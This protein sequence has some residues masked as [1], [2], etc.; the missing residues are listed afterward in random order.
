MTIEQAI[1]IVDAVCSVARMQR[2][3]HARVVE[4]LRL[5]R[6]ALEPAPPEQ[7]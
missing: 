5:I 4:A 3:D 2:D 7:G 6:E 1:Q